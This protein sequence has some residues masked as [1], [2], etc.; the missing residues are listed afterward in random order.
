MYKQGFDF[1]GNNAV[2]SALKTLKMHHDKLMTEIKCRLLPYL[3]GL[4]QRP[5]AV[6]VVLR[7]HDKHH[8]MSVEFKATVQ[9]P[10]VL[11][12]QLTVPFSPAA[13]RLHLPHLPATETT[14]VPEREPNACLIVGLFSKGH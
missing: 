1:S 13:H 2:H 5:S 12:T 3:P 4:D 9:A 8:L 6:H 11:H 10:G 14:Q 7:V